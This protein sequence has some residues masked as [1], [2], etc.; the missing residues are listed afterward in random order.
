[1]PLQT[2]AP[3]CA[4]AWTRPCS[5]SARP[6]SARPGPAAHRRTPPPLPERPTLRATLNRIKDDS[7]YPRSLPYR[8]HG[9]GLADVGASGQVDFYTGRSPGSGLME[10]NFAQ[11][12]AS[13]IRAGPVT[14]AEIDTARRLL[15]DP[16]FVAYHPL[17]S[18]LGEP[19]RPAPNVARPLGLSPTA[20]RSSP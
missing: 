19:S 10:A 16:G 17:Q 13:I 15:G 8:L 9:A 2:G 6:P 12:G 5:A 20:T 7:S 4:Q 18:A 11:A 3:S 1:V 14:A